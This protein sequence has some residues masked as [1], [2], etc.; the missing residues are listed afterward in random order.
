MTSKNMDPSALLGM[1]NA[2]SYLAVINSDGVDQE[3]KDLAKKSL[4]SSQYIMSELTGVVED[5]VREN[6]TPE[7]K[8][9]LSALVTEA[10][11]SIIPTE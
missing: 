3:T 1:I 9:M 4:K 2:N 8:K 11:S 7:M 6:L 10:I 5:L